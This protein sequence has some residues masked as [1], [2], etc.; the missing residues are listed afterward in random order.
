[1]THEPANPLTL[2]MFS[3]LVGTKFRV[4]LAASHQIEMEL[5]EAAP[6]PGV[7]R[8]GK[9]GGGPRAESFSLIFNGPSEPQLPQRIYHFEHDQAGSF[10]LFIVPVGRA[11]ATIQYQAVINRLAGPD[12]EQPC[13][14]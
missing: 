11:Q 7:N 1:M 6:G 9:T 8:P 3:T 2:E 13:K 10:D 5:A 12:V 14:E 4:H